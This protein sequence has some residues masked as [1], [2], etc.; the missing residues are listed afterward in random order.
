MNAKEKKEAAVDRYEVFYQRLRVLR[1][2]FHRIGRFDDANAKLDELCK[3]FVLKTL[4]RRFPS[5]CSRERLS[6]DY[7]HELAQD[8]LGDSSRTAAALHA[9]FA[10]LSSK[11][12][13]SFS[14]FGS[15]SALSIDPHDDEFARALV[16]VLE[17]MPVVG[18]D[19]AASWSFDLLN[20]AFGHFVQ[21][22]FRHR[23]EDAQYL[24]PPEVV[25]AMV[26]IG[27]S[28]MLE[29]H[30]VGGPR[31]DLLI[32][33]PTCGVGSFLAAA[34]CRARRTQLNCRPL[35]DQ[36]ENIGIMSK[37]DHR[38]TGL[39][40]QEN[41][42]IMVLGREIADPRKQEPHC[43]GINLYD[44]VFQNPDAGASESRAGGWRALPPVM[45]AKHRVNPKR[46]L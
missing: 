19:E 22:S 15:Q 40:A 45:I 21:D 10:E 6:F 41:P 9:V 17:A 38:H 12:R 20:E 13:E 35:A 44:L 25:A 27:L 26:D 34:Y 8:L 14:A 32:A 33:D 39:G 4:D 43:T 37:G 2:D 46:C 31:Q 1:E 24:T 18:S 28:D 16:P 5:K 42:R 29:D 3:L 36:R 23:K 7:L 30:S 11:D